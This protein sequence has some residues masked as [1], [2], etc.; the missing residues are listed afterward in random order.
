MRY[1]NRVIQ[2]IVIEFDKRAERKYSDGPN[3]ISMRFKLFRGP[4]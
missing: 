2:Y 4:I 1:I 3:R